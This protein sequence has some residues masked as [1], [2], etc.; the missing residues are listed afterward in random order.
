MLHGLCFIVYIK[1]EHIYVDIAEDAK[2]RFDAS[3]CELDRPLPRGKNKKI[4]GLTKDELC[5]KIM[6]EFVALRPKTYRYLTNH[7]DEK[8]KKQRSASLNKSLNL[9]IINIV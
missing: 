7:N 4:I 9:K 8:Q 2:T 6:T 3:N 1:A 5:G